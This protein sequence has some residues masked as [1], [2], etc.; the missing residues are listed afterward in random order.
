MR[1]K[2]VAGNWKM[3][4][5]AAALSELRALAALLPDRP[6]DIV[7][8]PPAPLLYRASEIV[9]G[10]PIAIGAQDCHRQ[11]S[12]A[13]T[14]DISAAMIAD[15]A[16]THVIVGH[17]ERRTGHSESN[18]DVRAKAEQAWAADL[19]AIICIGESA[20]D[21]A[22]GKT[23]DILAEQLSGSLADPATGANTVI[24]YEP[25][26]AIGTNNTP[27]LEQIVEAHDFIRTRL[28]DRFGSGIADAIPLLY[29]G[30][31]NAGNAETI[32]RAANVDGA[33]VGGA[34]LKA[35]DFAPIIAALARS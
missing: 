35:S 14:G 20:Q 16:A 21:R 22:Q 30:S 2:L 26:W 28:A 23:L 12:G 25:I 6:P 15:A 18:A 32:F 24:A 11:E 8:C 29:G 7:I 3:N 13:F 17:S 10:T 27:S 19:S 5:S 9:A 4:G 34:S 1:R 33:L 31:V